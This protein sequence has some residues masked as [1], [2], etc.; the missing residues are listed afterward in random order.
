MKYIRES[1]RQN[2]KLSSRLSP[3]LFVSNIYY[4]LLPLKK[5]SKPIYESLYELSDDS[6]VTGP[7]G[8]ANGVTDP[9]NGEGFVKISKDTLLWILIGSSVV[10]LGMKSV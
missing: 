5:P 8:S 9:E 4:Q 1:R 2:L 7:E 6:D 10:S 3:K